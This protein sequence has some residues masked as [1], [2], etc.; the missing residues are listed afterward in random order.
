[1]YLSTFLVKSATLCAR[2]LSDAD[3]ISPMLSKLDE[4]LFLEDTVDRE[5]KD[6]ETDFVI[7]LLINLSS[8]SNLLISD[9]V[10]LSFRFK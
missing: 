10:S 3:L 8:F 9:R 6:G 2:L 7:E 5:D 4:T 1:M